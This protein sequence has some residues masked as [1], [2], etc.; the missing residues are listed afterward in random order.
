VWFRREAGKNLAIE[1]GM[2]LP[3]LAGYD[4][5]IA[6]GLLAHESAPSLLGLESNVFIAGD[7]LIL[8]E[9]SSGEHLNAM[10]DRED[11]LLVRIEL[12]D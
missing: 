5:A 1:L 3:G 7:A 8:G 10:T 2:R 11:P 4:M 6:N 9:T 12:P